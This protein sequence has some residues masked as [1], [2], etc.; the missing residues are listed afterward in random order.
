MISSHQL[1]RVFKLL[2]A[3][4]FGLLAC[5]V[6]VRVSLLSPLF[7]VFSIKVLINTL[8]YLPT[9][10]QSFYYAKMGNFATFISQV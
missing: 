7:P 10:A 6:A 1:Y 4:C 8:H 9:S 3:H 5:K 2:S